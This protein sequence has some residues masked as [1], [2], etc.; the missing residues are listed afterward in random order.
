MHVLLRLLMQKLG[1]DVEAV[2]STAQ[3]Q[4]KKVNFESFERF[5]DHLR[6]EDEER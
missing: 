2:S 3:E 6:Y 4:L 1:L 5:M